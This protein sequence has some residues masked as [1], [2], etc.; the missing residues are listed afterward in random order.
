LGRE[1]SK[2]PLDGRLTDLRAFA[3]FGDEGVDLLLA[4]STNAEVPGFTTP[5]GVD[6][7]R[8]SGRSALIRFDRSDGLANG[9][10]TSGCQPRSSRVLV[11][12][13]NTYG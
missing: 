13:S 4:D 9:L 3:R 7:Q 10:K 6:A 5:E 1:N 11:L 2:L 12:I 8:Q